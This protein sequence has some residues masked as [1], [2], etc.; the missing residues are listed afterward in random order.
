MSKL[1]DLLDQ[2]ADKFSESIGVMPPTTDT[3]FHRET[4]AN[5]PLKNNDKYAG[6]TNNR[7]TGMREMDIDRVVADPAQPRRTF[8][9]AELKRLAG[10][11]EKHGVMQPISVRWSD[12]SS[13][14]IIIDGERRFRAS[15]MASKQSIPCVFDE[16]LS[17]EP[18]IRIRQL[19][20]NC[21]RED[22]LPIEQARAFKALMELAGWSGQQLAN[23]INVSKATVS[24]SL[25]ML[26]G[27][28]AFFPVPG[29]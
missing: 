28:E 24:K 5:K 6:R 21:Q 11:I 8:D 1:K 13:Q 25:A 3:Q 27:D 18:T 16:T 15:K 14:W 10:S 29:D 9:N 4:D 19:V 2:H 26:N 17:D 23:E 7:A 22:L 20:A 12:E